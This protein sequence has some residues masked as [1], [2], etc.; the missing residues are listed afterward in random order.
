MTQ[1]SNHFQTRDTAPMRAAQAIVSQPLLI[2]TVIAAQALILVVVV[3]IT[4][5]SGAG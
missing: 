5:P 1:R 4:T 3:L 2:N